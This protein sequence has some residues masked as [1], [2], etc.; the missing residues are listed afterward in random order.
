MFPLSGRLFQYQESQIQIPLGSGHLCGIP[1]DILD[2]GLPISD[3]PLYSSRSLYY[4]MVSRA[5]FGIV[6]S[7]G[8][9]LFAIWP[10]ILLLEQHLAMAQVVPGSAP[11]P[12]NTTAGAPANTTAGAPANTTAGTI[13]NFNH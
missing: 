13:K 10:N 4:E 5:Y 6:L 1:R 2:K 8:A 12:A 9:V 3:N 7:I 11:P